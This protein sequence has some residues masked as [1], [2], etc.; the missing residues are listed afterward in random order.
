M[1][2]RCPR[3]RRQRPLRHPPRRGPPARP[4][5][6]SDGRGRGALRHRP[7]DGRGQRRLRRAVALTHRPSVIRQRNSPRAHTAVAGSWTPQDS[8]LIT[9]NDCQE[10]SRISPV[11]RTPSP[12]NF[13]A[14]TPTTKH[15]QCADS[16]SWIALTDGIVLTRQSSKGRVQERRGSY[17]CANLASPRTLRPVHQR[18][19]PG[20]APPRDPMRANSV[21]HCTQNHGGFPRNGRQCSGE[22]TR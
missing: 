1:T 21:A 20:R 19:C 6:R 12:L 5:E 9:A 8:R 17:S 2:P 4:H 15:G 22:R 14:A 16:R 11:P 7:G 13:E 18:H 3:P 10:V